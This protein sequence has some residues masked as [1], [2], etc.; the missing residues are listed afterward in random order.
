ME[1]W[2]SQGVRCCC[3]AVLAALAKRGCWV[4]IWRLERWCCHCGLY[5]T[6]F[7]CVFMKWLAA[8]LHLECSNF[9]SLVRFRK[10]WS[11]WL[12]LRSWQGPGA[13]SRHEHV[14]WCHSG[15]S[16]IIPSFNLSRVLDVTLKGFCWTLNTSFTSLLFIV[17]YFCFCK[18][19][20][21]LPKWLYRVKLLRGN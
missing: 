7:C 10:A 12:K 3:V 21:S 2:S 18:H 20:Q 5:P 8:L 15:Y 16:I 13:R 4:C 17:I 14:G 19:V 1:Q 6:L 11:C 9:A